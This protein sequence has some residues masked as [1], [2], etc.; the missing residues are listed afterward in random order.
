MQTEAPVGVVLDGGGLMALSCGHDGGV[1]AHRQLQ[2]QPQIGTVA[3]LIAGGVAAAVSKTCTAPL[4]PL[5]ILFQVTRCYYSSSLATEK[6]KPLALASRIVYEEGFS[7]FWKGNLVTIAPRLP[8]S[9][10]SFYAYEWYKNVLQ[11]IPGL[12]KHREC[13]GADVCL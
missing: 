1:G 5:T 2:H 9:S 3:H 7:A 10:I 12:D 8:Y 4:A 11:L 13:V 6:S